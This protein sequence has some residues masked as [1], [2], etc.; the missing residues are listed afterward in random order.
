[1]LDVLSKLPD[2]TFFCRLNPIW[3]SEDAVANDVI[4]DNLC[5]VKPKKKAFPKQKP[6]E[7]YIKTFSNVEILNHMENS[8]VDN[9]IEF[10]GMNKLNEVY[11]K[12][13][14]E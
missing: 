8:L 13:L 5:R 3:I 10:L 6:A 2:K 1:M 4:Y 14:A 11:K 7:N 9:S 12:M